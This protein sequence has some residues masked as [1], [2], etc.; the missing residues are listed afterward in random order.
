MLILIRQ[1]VLIKISI[2]FN[3][4]PFVCLDLVLYCNVNHSTSLVYQHKENLQ[5]NKICNCMLYC[6]SHCE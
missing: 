2:F 5:K 1:F 4:Y 3:F 6:T